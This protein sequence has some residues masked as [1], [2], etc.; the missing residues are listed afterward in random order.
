MS[1]AIIAALIAGV[2]CW[3][4]GVNY[5]QNDIHF[6]DHVQAKGGI[7]IDGYD[8][9]KIYKVTPLPSPPGKEG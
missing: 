8:K 6:R 9:N 4:L 7:F 3:F 5:G 2:A 1:N